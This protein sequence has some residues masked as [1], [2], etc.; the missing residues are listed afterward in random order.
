ML[1]QV[2]ILFSYDMHFKSKFRSLVT[3]LFRQKLTSHTPSIPSTNSSRLDH[4]SQRILCET[5][6][7]FRQSCCC[8]LLLKFE[9]RL[10]DYFCRK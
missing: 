10:S 4:Q 5:V 6:V 9:V 3:K 7:I 1:V 8:E 2:H